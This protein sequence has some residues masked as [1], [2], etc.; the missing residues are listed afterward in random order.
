MRILFLC[1]LA[2]AVMAAEPAL[3]T[4]GLRIVAV[5]IGENKQELRPFNW[6]AGTTVALR[7]QSRD[8]GL[9][10]IDAD[11]SE[12]KAFADDQGTDLL[13]EV[14]GQHTWNR[15]GFGNTSDVSE[16]GTQLLFELSAP[17]IPVKGARLINVRG[18]IAVIQAKTFATETI[19]AVS[20]KVGEKIKSTAVTYEIT[21]IGKPQWGDAA[22]A[23]TLKTTDDVDLIKGLTFTDEKGTVLEVDRG[24]SSRM[25]WQ[26]NITTEV[27]YNFKEQRDACALQI[28]SWTD[29]QIK[30]VPFDVDVAVGL[31]Q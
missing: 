9:L 22:L 4:V 10:G 25:G 31:Q 1:C 11:A 3:S 17:Q 26:G 15:N 7:Y 13:K 5:G 21:Q 23:V 14:P 12:L 16:D 18:H 19:H 6:F 28:E 27:T 20:L 30:T 8:G 2:C 24:M 29:R